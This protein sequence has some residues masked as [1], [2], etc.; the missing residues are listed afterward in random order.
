A[1]A[2][3]IPSRRTRPGLSGAAVGR[4]TRRTRATLPWSR[5][6]N[7]WTG[8]RSRSLPA[9]HRTSR[10]SLIR[11]PGHPERCGDR[12]RR[13][14]CDRIGFLVAV[15]VC[16]GLLAARW[17][18]GGDVRELVGDRQRVRACAYG[19]LLL[20]LRRRAVAFVHEPAH[21]FVEVVGARLALA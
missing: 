14:R 17:T 15:V 5:N 9:G 8:R 21:H 20:P 1:H 6:R 3:R 12:P 18:C 4:R 19:T 7:R 2:P 16:S 11:R 10:S 13:L